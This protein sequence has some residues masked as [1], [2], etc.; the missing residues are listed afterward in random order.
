MVR[1]SRYWAHV[2]CTLCALLLLSSAG[3]S[4]GPRY[5]VEV[6][7]SLGCDYSR[8]NA[9]NRAGQVVGYADTLPGPGT[10]VEHA[11][12]WDG[13]VTM[14]LGTL[15]GARSRAYDVSNFGV[16]AGW[17]SGSDGKM[18]PA[19]WDSSGVQE[20]PTLGGPTGAA[21]AINDLGAVVGNAYTSPSVYHAALWG[22][23]GVVD[24]GTLGGDYS[25]AY[26]INVSGQAVGGADDS[27]GRE[28]AV[29]WTDD[30]SIE[31]INGLP[32][33]TWSTARG[34][35]DRGDIILWGDTTGST[36]RAALWSGG[37]VLDLGTFGGTQSWA[38]GL[39]NAGFVVGW[40]EL[41]AGNYHAFV[42]DGSELIDL[43]TVGGMFSSA[44]GINDFGTVVG[45]AQGSDG[46]WYAVQWVPVPEP[47]TFLC[48]GAGV[49]ALI[50]RP[51]RRR[52]G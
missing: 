37:Q 13:S 6:L 45:S 29:R 44:Y 4:G 31:T 7:G 48:V 42:F 2:L 17:A 16:A 33:G 43:G 30:G 38:Y 28:R 47:A 35:N 32:G 51:L 52:K 36:G 20:L 27:L 10:A 19:Y 46:L 14:D 22:P 25:I 39:N 12:L 41:A 21:W 5:R 8:A 9:I 18:K 26:D 11:F 50:L 1:V 40:G 34:I 15:G 23:D 3:L 49:F 24:L